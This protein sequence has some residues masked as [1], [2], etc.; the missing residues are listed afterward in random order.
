MAPRENGT[1][2]PVM[3][4]QRRSTPLTS[5]RSGWWLAAAAWPLQR[6][7][8]ASTS[9]GES[10]RCID[11]HTLS[12]VIAGRRASA[13]AL[14]PDADAPFLAPLQRQRP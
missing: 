3:S 5:A 8:G 13:C 14:E 12:D 10:L 2:A 11:S 1:C 7:P 4:Q 6:G 9:R